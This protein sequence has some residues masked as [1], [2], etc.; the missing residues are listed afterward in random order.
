MS[1][2]YYSLFGDPDPDAAWQQTPL[3][4]HV[5]AHGFDV[6]PRKAQRAAK[7]LSRALR[8]MRGE[9]APEFTCNEF[10]AY[11]NAFPDNLHRWIDQAFTFIRDSRWRP[12][13]ERYPKLA[14]IKPG[15]IRIVLVPTPI[16]VPH[17][18]TFAAAM[19]DMNT[20]LITACV[21]ALSPGT[22]GNP[23]LNWLRKVEDLVRWEIGNW[24]AHW[25]LKLD[26]KAREIGDGAVC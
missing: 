11:Y 18:Q 3:G 1:D 13:L 10:V 17:Y 7:R 12:C 21:A 22:P 9:G 8:W 5:Q 23:E 16:Y 26:P 25:I 2:T 4:L 6:R 15:D 19:T 20:G 14:G 24:G